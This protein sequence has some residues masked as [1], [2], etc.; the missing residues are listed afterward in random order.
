MTNFVD[1]KRVVE[2][3]AKNCIMFMELGTALTKAAAPR[4]IRPTSFGHSVA[5]LSHVAI[6]H[7]SAA[8]EQTTA[9]FPAVP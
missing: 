2:N 5:K 9:K 1:S 7:E 6:L 3:Q 8:D 4:I